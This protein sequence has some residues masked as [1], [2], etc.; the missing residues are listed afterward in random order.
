MAMEQEKKETGA[1]GLG[2]GVGVDLNLKLD[3]IKNLVHTLDDALRT[4]GSAVTDTLS[5]AFNKIKELGPESLKQQSEQGGFESQYNDLVSKLQQA[6]SRG[7]QEAGSL[8]RRMGESTEHAGRKI[9]ERGEGEEP[10][11]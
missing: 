1:A 9:E 7:E 5:D 4:T 8:L 6:A 11:H 2:V 10:R 3:M